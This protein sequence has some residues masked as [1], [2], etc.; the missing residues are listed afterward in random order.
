MIGVQ[1]L[2]HILQLDIADTDSLPKKVF[3]QSNPNLLPNNLARQLN[4]YNS[5]PMEAAD[6]IF[7]G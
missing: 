2:V 4:R 5:I 3:L 7:G 6:E 1:V